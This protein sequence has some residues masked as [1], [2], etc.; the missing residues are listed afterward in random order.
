MADMA[1]QIYLWCIPIVALSSYWKSVRL[2][3]FRIVDESLF[4]AQ[5]AI[6]GH[7]GFI[8]LWYAFI[9]PAD[10]V[11]QPWLML[12][13]S[14]FVVAVIVTRRPACQFS[15]VI[16]GILMFGI[17]T[18]GVLGISQSWQGYSGV[19]DWANWF[20]IFVVGVLNQITLMGW[21]NVDR[22]R[23]FVSRLTGGASRI[24]DPKGN[25]GLAR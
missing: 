7:I 20:C 16:C 3:P 15:G 8:W 9:R 11:G 14:Y 24:S 25:T 6:L 13:L 12:C 18:N 21:A 2:Q 22:G 10:A 5:T 19:L 17:L 23:R 1:Y 4:K